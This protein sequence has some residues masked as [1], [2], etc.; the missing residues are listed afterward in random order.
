M[1]N[2][3]AEEAV[4]SGWCVACTG[5]DGASAVFP[6]RA[7]PAAAGTTCPLPLQTVTLC[8][9]GCCGVGGCPGDKERCPQRHI[10]V[11]RSAGPRFLLVSPPGAGTESLWKQHST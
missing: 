1:L 6:G 8:A 9:G 11:A 2:F 7:V 10:W 5:G 4:P 3:H